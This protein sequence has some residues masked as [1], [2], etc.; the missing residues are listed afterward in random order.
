MAV[1]YLPGLGQQV[2]LGERLFHEGHA[3][4]EPALGGQDRPGVAGHEDHFDLRL[5][6]PHFFRDLLAEHVRHDHVGDQQVNLARVGTGHAKGI[7][8]VRCGDHLVAVTGEDPP[9]HLAQRF[10]VLNDQDSLPLGC[11]LVGHGLYDLDGCLRGNRQRDG[12]GRAVAGFGVDPDVP[13]G[14]GDDPVDDGQAE[15]G[16]AVL[17]SGEERLEYVLGN[18]GGHSGA[19][20]ADPQPHVAALSRP[21]A[22]GD[23]VGV[24]GYVA[25]V[26]GQ[27]AASGHGVAGVDREVHQHLVQLA[28]VG[29]DR[30][31]VT[32][33][34]GDQLDVLADGPA[35]HFLDRC[36]DAVE[37][38]N[39][40]P[41]HVAAGEDEQLVG[42]PG[43]P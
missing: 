17:L 29:Q 37:V 23:G 41:D 42:K 7:Q 30:P 6:Q 16:S 1:E 24:H 19:G 33:E 2:G 35:Q 8:A 12:E 22:P 9:G 39:P 38:E 15:P 26:D 18:L 27:R 3:R 11:P 32:G 13:A 25:G 20:V 31:Q 10:L 4:V 36:D 5:D 14:L 40:R 34:R 28:G 43:R 21:G